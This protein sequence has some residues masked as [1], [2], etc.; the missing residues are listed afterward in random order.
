MSGTSKHCKQEVKFV[1]AEAMRVTGL[2]HLRKLA[3]AVLHSVI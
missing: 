2:E 1:R 3:N